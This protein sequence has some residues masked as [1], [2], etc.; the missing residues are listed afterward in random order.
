MIVHR[1]RKLLLLL[2]AGPLALA[3]AV[4]TR[5]VRRIAADPSRRIEVGRGYVRVRYEI[6]WFNR[7]G[8]PG[9]GGEPIG[10]FPRRAEQS[11]R[12]R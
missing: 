7:P 11:R 3:F 4:R 5:V 8:L 6:A 2:V 1:S 10:H 12:E 9:A